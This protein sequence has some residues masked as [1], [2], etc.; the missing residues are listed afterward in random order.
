[1]ITVDTG[2]CPHCRQPG[3]VTIPD[4]VAE[5]YRQWRRGAGYIQTMLPELTADQREQLMTGT[6][7]SCFDAMLGAEEEEEE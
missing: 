7:G 6:H 4:D 1:M 5:R 3:Q 2:L